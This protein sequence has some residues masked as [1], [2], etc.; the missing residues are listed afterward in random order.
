MMPEYKFMYSENF[1]NDCYPLIEKKPTHILHLSQK[2]SL[3]ETGKKHR[4]NS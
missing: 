3:R 4:R 1:L 2:T